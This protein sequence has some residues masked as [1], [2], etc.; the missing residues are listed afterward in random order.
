[1]DMLVQPGPEP[2]PVPADRVPGQVEVI[3]PGRI[4]ER[5]G[6]MSAVRYDSYVADQPGRQHH[7]SWQR[8]EH[9]DDLLD[10]DHR[11]GRGEHALFLHAGDAPVLDVALA[12]GALGVDDGYVRAERRDGCEPLARERADDLGDAGRLGGQAGAAVSAQDGEGQPGRACHVPVGHSRVAVL[13]DLERDGPCVLNRVPEPVQGSDARIACPGEHQLAGA[14]RPDQL[15][16]DDVGRHPDQGQ[17]LTPLPYHLVAC[18]MRDQV[19]ETLHCDG[20]PV[21]D[22]CGD[23]L[24]QRHDLSHPEPAFLAAC[25]GNDIDRPLSE[26]LCGLRSILQHVGGDGERPIGRRYA[27]VEGDLQEDLLDLGD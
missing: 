15:V 13:L 27:R 12:V 14:A 7:G 26:Q 16:V 8:V 23:R 2:H 1:M 17:V 22:G 5:V 19:G 24:G 11:S 6:G 10:R 20:V 4:A 9:V 3:V 21:V 25:T 18:G